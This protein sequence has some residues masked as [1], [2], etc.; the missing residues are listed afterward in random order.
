MVSAVCVGWICVVVCR[1]TFAP[2]IRTSPYTLFGLPHTTVCKTSDTPCITLCVVYVLCAVVLCI[3]LCRVSVEYLYWLEFIIVSPQP[4]AHFHRP[5][6]TVHTVDPSL[7]V[8]PVIYSL[9]NMSDT[10]DSAPTWFAL[11][12]GDGGGAC[13]ATTYLCRDFVQLR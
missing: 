5:N 10:S 6:T 1:K 8:H 11:G 2:H 13:D 4:R 7:V 3:H 9:P 12:D